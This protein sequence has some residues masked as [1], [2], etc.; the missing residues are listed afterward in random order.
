LRRS[1]SICANLLCEKGPF[2]S[3]DIV[4]GRTL[5][6]FIKKKDSCTWQKSLFCV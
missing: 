5:L 3:K 6:V 2:D 4:G 1:S